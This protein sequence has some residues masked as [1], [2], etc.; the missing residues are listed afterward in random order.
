MI[1]DDPL[2]LVKV[3]VEQSESNSCFLTEQSGDAPELRTVPSTSTTE[4][5]DKF[6]LTDE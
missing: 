1:D 3:I 2:E 5:A 4:R 6:T